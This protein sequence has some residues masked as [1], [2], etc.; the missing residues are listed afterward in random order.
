VAKALAVYLHAVVW[1]KKH[2]A[3][4]VT[5]LKQYNETNGVSL[6]QASLERTVTRSV[7]FDLKDELKLFDR[8]AGASQVD[9]WMSDLS[10]YLVGVGTLSGV[11]DPK[12]YIDDRFLRMIEST[13]KLRS[14]ANGE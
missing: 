4:A 14:F 5:Y 6:S 1:L 11:Q 2:P 7:T 8:S 3:E 9:K 13:P 10:Q 12:T